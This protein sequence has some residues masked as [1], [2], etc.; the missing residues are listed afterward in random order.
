MSKV[1]RWNKQAD[2][3]W[4]RKD[5]LLLVVH[6]PS[7]KGY[8]RFVVI[9][10][11]GP[12]HHPD[13]LIASGTLE[14]VGNAKVAAERTAERLASAGHHQRW[15]AAGSRSV[16]HTSRSTLSAAGRARTPKRPGKTAGCEREA[17]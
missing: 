11:Q 17:L 10:R 16:S 13:R 2:M 7:T 1:H 8:A 9:D 4:M 3:L 14:D 15:P 6:L 12:K 5:G